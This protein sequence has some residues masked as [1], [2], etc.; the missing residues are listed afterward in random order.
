MQ[1]QKQNRMITSGCK[2]QIDIT[3]QIEDKGFCIDTK[4]LKDR[5]EHILNGNGAF[6]G[7]C[8]LSYSNILQIVEGIYLYEFFPMVA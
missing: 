4:Q 7:S 5:F 6:L 8:I 2:T 3:D 1:I